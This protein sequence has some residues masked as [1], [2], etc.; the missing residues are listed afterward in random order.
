MPLILGSKGYKLWQ[1]YK[2]KQE[3][4]K[5]NS[6]FSL[7]RQILFMK[8]Y[9]NKVFAS[10]RKKFNR[11]QRIQFQT[12]SII[13]KIRLNNLKLSNIYYPKL[14]RLKCT[15]TKRDLNIKATILQI[16]NNY[17][18]SKTALRRVQ[19][20]SHKPRKSHNRQNSF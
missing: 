14:K 10:Q 11:C 1:I 18:Q 7:L 4:Y 3:I 15:C 9:R 13:H 12:F 19:Y 6:N 2:L 20:Y 8:K 17:Q 5:N 16:T